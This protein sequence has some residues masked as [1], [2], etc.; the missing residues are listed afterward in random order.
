MVVKGLARLAKG[1][2]LPVGFW[3]AGLVAFTVLAIDGLFVGANPVFVIARLTAY[4]TVGTLAAV[5]VAFVAML[6]LACG[7]MLTWLGEPTNPRLIA[8]AMCRSYWWVGSYVW[9]G[10]ALLAIEPPTALT[11]LEMAEPRALEARIGG[12]AAF[13]WMA[14]L[15]H[16]A[17]AGFL[18]T[19]A[20]LLARKSKP[21]NAI[22]S[23]AFGAAALAA[24]TTA[25]GLLAGEPTP[26]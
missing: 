10:V 13:T 14:R 25:L 26:V 18:V 21:L 8:V 17:L 6:G 23:V 9:L 19:V 5:T 15:R 24:L 3:L 4:V 7:M 20:W 1:P 2:L 16:V 11:A 12:T 22:L